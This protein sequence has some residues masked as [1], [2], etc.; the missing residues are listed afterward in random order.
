MGVLWAAA[1]SRQV[2]PVQMR[3]STQWRPLHGSCRPP[4]AGGSRVRP[5]PCAR[6]LLAAA[7]LVAAAHGALGQ[8]SK[9]HKLALAMLA[10]ALGRLVHNGRPAVA[11]PWAGAH[12]PG[13]EPVY[14][15]Y[16]KHDQLVCGATVHA[17]RPPACWR[18]P[19]SSPAWTSQSRGH[20]T[21]IPP[22]W[23]GGQ[24]SASASLA[25]PC[26]HCRPQP[27][28]PPQQPPGPCSSLASCA[29]CAA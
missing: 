26:I 7:C 2:L 20:S 29:H 5:S 23:A 25:G 18:R 6:Q 16:Q 11:R 14:K 28:A 27:C 9:P 15:A 8:Q 21:S 19:S 17:V 22:G 3:T 4:P 13:C 10:R 1:F 12:T 24:A